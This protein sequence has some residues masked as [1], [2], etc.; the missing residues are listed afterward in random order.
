MFTKVYEKAKD[1]FKENYK[2]IIFLI[3]FTI[4][5]NI[6]LPFYINAPG[7]LMNV[8]DRV[9]IE[10]SY[11]S[12]GTLNIAYVTEMRANIPALILSL[13]NK[14]WDILKEEEL[15]YENETMEDVYYRERLM[16]EES[17]NNAIIVGFEKAGKKVEITSSKLFVTYIDENASTDLKIGDE[18]LSIDDKEITSTNEINDILSKKKAN[19]EITLKVIRD[20]KEVTKKATLR[21]EDKKTVI[22]ILIT[23]KKEVE[24]IPKVDI[25]FKK[26]ESGPSGGLMTSLAIYNYLTEEDITHGKTIVGTGTIDINGNVG[27]IGGVKYKLK[28]AIKNGAQVF[29]V[30]NGEN[31]ED[32][33]KLKKEN[34]YDIE[35]IGVSTIDDALNYLSKTKK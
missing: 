7:G 20:K 11:K 10:D 27:S 25:K 31:Y 30:P 34:N 2:T 21:K 35:I 24:T 1:F 12:K 19:D 3:L 6:N 23:E 15:T 17:I 32:A 5:I 26:S 4:I 22:G 18:I 28:G 14:D 33:I 9:I 8:S 29:L 16:L 13:F